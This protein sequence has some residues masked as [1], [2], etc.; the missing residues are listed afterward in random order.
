MRAGLSEIMTVS[1]HEQEDS[2]RQIQ[3]NGAESRFTLAKPLHNVDSK[4]YTPRAE[5]SSSEEEDDDETSEIESRLDVVSTERPFR[6][7]DVPLHNP[8]DQSQIVPV[9]DLTYSK[10]PFIDTHMWRDLNTVDNTL[11]GK[12]LAA[13]AVETLRRS[14]VSSRR[15]LS[16]FSK[17]DS[18]DATL[19]FS[20]RTSERRLNNSAEAVKQSAKAIDMAKQGVGS[21]YTLFNR[22]WSV[23]LRAK[24]TMA[25]WSQLHHRQKHTDVQFFVGA[26]G[27]IPVAT[28]KNVSRA[29]RVVVLERECDG[30]IVYT[31]TKQKIA[32]H[33]VYWISEGRR[34]VTGV[35]DQSGCRFVLVIRKGRAV[36]KYRGD[37]LVVPHLASS[38]ASVRTPPKAFGS[39]VTDFLDIGEGSV[40]KIASGMDVVLAF[41]CMILADRF[42][43]FKLFVPQEKVRSEVLEGRFE[44]GIGEKELDLYQQT[45]RNISHG[46]TAAA[47][48]LIY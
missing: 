2:L 15:S 12:P 35:V 1:I 47:S 5:S 13:G 41:A 45:N 11:E 36:I 24:K 9:K 22:D 31:F 42:E 14:V 20:R 43:N 25:H 32:G 38:R 7:I 6:P 23:L 44:T 19:H 40:V 46:T 10:E 4:L 48:S 3:K 34:A 8:V 16:T 28:L 37:S 21:A 29:S 18:S 17:N 33:R 26:T 39:I 27:D 30:G